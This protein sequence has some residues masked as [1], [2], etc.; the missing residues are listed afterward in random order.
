MQSR[1]RILTDW[2][3]SKHVGRGYKALFYGPPGTGKT[4]TATL[5]GQR[6]GLDVYRVDL[7]MVVSKYIGETEKNLGLIFDMAAERDWILFFDEA[8]ALFGTRTATSSAHDRYANQEVAYLLQRIED[9]ESLVIL[10]SNLRSN[11]DDAF[12]RRFQ[13]A[14]GFAQPTVAERL[15]LW[16][17]ILSSLPLDGDV[18]AKALAREHELTGAA[19]SNIARH[20]AILALRRG[21]VRLGAQDI[22]SAI[23]AEMRKEGRTT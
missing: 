6:T 20:A 17:N 11:I 8:D 13:S 2:G 15:Q 9:C 18:S 10:A 14:V 4:L 22:Q 21:A 1:D 23:T 5:L 7:S 16:R 12:F 3:L 19:I